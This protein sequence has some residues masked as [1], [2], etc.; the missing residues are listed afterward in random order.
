MEPYGLSAEVLQK[1]VTVFSN[2]SQIVQ[3]KLYG[4]RAMGS[5]WRGSDIDLAIYGDCEEIL[6]KIM[7]QLD[8]LPTPYKFDVTDYS[9]IDNLEL[10]EHIDRVGKTLYQKI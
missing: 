5:Y 1:I 10:K 7:T 8:E 3:V 2:Y 9:R 6:G 4:S